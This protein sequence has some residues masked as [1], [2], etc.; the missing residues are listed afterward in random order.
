MITFTGV[1]EPQ[2]LPLR[3]SSSVYEWAKNND[4]DKAVQEEVWLLCMDGKGRARK[5]ELIGRGSEDSCPVVPSCVFRAILLS[6]YNRMILVHN[7]PSGDPAPSMA[8]REFTA[9][10]DHG[11]PLVGVKLLDHVIVGHEGYISFRDKGFI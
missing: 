9:L 5:V 3:E 8:D 6:G 1:R 2:S 4:L 10:I 11:A 7:H